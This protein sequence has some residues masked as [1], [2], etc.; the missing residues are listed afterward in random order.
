MGFINLNYQNLQTVIF[1][2]RCKS[3]QTAKRGEICRI[4]GCSVSPSPPGNLTP[5]R[6]YLPHFQSDTFKQFLVYVYTGKVR[7][8]LY[9]FEMILLENKQDFNLRINRISVYKTSVWLQG[10]NQS[11]TTTE[12]TYLLQFFLTHVILTSTSNY[13]VNS[14]VCAM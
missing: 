7:K 5:A 10:K 2:C 13:Q 12:K 4:P 9:S 11:P 14:T 3:F 1:C 8:S 6:L